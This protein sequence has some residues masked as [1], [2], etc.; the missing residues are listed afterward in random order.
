MRGPDLPEARDGVRVLG[1]AYLYAV[2]LKR[3]RFISFLVRFSAVE[4][5]GRAVW[6]RATTRISSSILGVKC[7]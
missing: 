1:W 2:S 7:A 5:S 3:V 4:P 6:E